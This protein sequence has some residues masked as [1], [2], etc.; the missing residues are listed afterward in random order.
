M[1]QLRREPRKEVSPR[2][3]TS[4]WFT[5]SI[6]NLLEPHDKAI[7]KANGRLRALASVLV[8]LFLLLLLLPLPLPLQFVLGLRVL[9]TSLQDIF[10]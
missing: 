10:A 7:A 9:Q 4:S 5:S 2:L 3:L 6:G 8:V 1:E